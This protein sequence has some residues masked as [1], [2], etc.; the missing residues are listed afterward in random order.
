MSHVVALSRSSTILV[1]EEN[2]FEMNLALS[3]NRDPR[4]PV[5]RQNLENKEDKIFEMRNGLVYRRKNHNLLFY[6]PESMKNQIMHKYHDELGHRGADKTCDAIERNYWFP[7]MHKKVCLYIQ[8]CLKCIAYSLISGKSEGYLHTIPKG[9]VPFHMVHI[10]H[11]GPIEKQRLV[12]QY[13]LVV[14]DAFTKFT[15]L[16]A[17]KTT[18]SKEV[19]NALREYF[20]NYSRPLVIISDRGSSFTS[21]EFTDF[22]KEVNVQHIKITTRSPKA[23]GQVERVNRVLGPMISKYI[24][25]ASGNYWYK[26]L[27]KIEYALN[28]T[29]CRS[30][31]ETPSKLLFGVEQRNIN[32]DKINDYL[33]Q[34]TLTSDRDLLSMRVQAVKNIEKSQ[35][36]N[37]RIIRV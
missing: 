15:K 10:D 14:I 9:N 32:I 4:I 5:L 3:Q 30:T 1:L 16:Y 2:P 19:I 33:K 21:K 34:Q 8:N 27:P 37:K 29:I 6:V 20:A 24:D 31:G 17:T 26:I 25:N 11:Y 12:K 35:E 7:K 18:A 28:N 23:N 22:L 13:I 36:Y